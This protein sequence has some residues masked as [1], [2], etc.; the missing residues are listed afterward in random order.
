VIQAGNASKL[1]GRLVNAS[2]EPLANKRVVI[3]QRAA[4]SGRFTPLSRGTALT[5][6]N[7]SF[8]LRVRP[9]TTTF[10]RAVFRGAEGEFGRSVSPAVRV[11]VVGG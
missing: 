5:R 3:R 7:G 11:R 2:G 10:Y 6:A 8:V 1:R 9:G 4:G